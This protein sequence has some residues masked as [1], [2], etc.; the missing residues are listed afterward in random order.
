VHVLY[1]TQ[2][3]VTESNLT[4][5][6]GPLVFLLAKTSKLFYLIFPDERHLRKALHYIYTFLLLFANLSGILLKVE[7]VS[8]TCDSSSCSQRLQNYFIWSSL[9]N[10]I[11][12]KHYIIYIHFYYCLQT[13]HEY[14]WKWRMCHWLATVLLQTK[15]TATI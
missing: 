14:C 7:N 2:A 1:L 8:L 3:K 15:L 10:V 5:M 6:L 9:M 11:Y 13:C 4:S 12:E